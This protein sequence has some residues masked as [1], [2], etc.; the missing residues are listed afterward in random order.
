[1]T[2]ICSVALLTGTASHTTAG[3]VPWAWNL[4]FGPGPGYGYGG[5]SP[6][7]YTSWGYESVV[8][9]GYLPSATCCSYGPASETFFL[10]PVT[11]A[12]APSVVYSVPT[13]PW[14]TTSAVPTVVP[15]ETCPV[16]SCTWSSHS[17]PVDDSLPPEYDVTSPPATDTPAP[18]TFDDDG[19]SSP[20][21]QDHVNGAGRVD[22]RLYRDEDFEQPRSANP[23][24]EEPAIDNFPPPQRRSPVDD[25]KPELF[26]DGQGEAAR[27][28]VPDDFREF[29]VQPPAEATDASDDPDQSSLPGNTRRFLRAR[30]LGL[31]H[32]VTWTATTQN[33]ER[34][35][36]ARRASGSYSARSARSG[37]PL[38]WI[39]VPRD[40]AI[41]RR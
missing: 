11:A 7:A 9:S 33:L 4:I 6:P 10:R 19:R 28:P 39:T 2:L 22:T 26:D 16:Q 37:Q 12:Y 5:W 30:A 29:N 21:D 8:F 18:K 38:R 20:P 24:S 23:D 34:T 35:R 40:P 15:C 3:I 41:A 17:A 27:V 25:P 1:M 36:T 13:Q 32:V 31:D 14:V